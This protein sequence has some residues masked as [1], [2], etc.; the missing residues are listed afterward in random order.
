MDWRT[1]PFRDTG[2]GK[3]PE[4]PADM[5]LKEFR[6]L[7]D[8]GE[9]LLIKLMGENVPL[10]DDELSFLAYALTDV[11]YDKAFT[12]AMLYPQAAYWRYRANQTKGS[13]R[14]TES[15][16]KRYVKSIEP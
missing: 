13:L 14:T 2:C 4:W 12:V 9:A 7:R 11:D 5:L 10:D 3:L 16:T 6:P 8:L 1:R 15:N